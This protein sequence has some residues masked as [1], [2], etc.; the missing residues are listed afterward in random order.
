VYGI[1]GG[2]AIRGLVVWIAVIRLM[3]A[4]LRG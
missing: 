2:F 1:A 3:L 4:L